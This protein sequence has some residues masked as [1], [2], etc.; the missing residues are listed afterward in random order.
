MN[1][2]SVNA[3][4]QL[5]AL[6]QYQADGLQKGIKAVYLQV[7]LKSN[8][9]KEDLENGKYDI[10]FFSLES[11]LGEHHDLKEQSFEGDFN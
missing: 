7:L 4:S 10:I 3:V 11:L 2:L 1:D 9:T 5:V 6:M 8:V